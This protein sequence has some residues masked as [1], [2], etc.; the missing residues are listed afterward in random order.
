MS[1]IQEVIN[2]LE[3]AA[4]KLGMSVEEAVSILLGK[5]P[6]HVVVQAHAQTEETNAKVAENNAASAQAAQVAGA[7][8]NVSGAA[9]GAA[10]SAAGGTI[11]DV[12]TNK[13]TPGA[14]A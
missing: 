7:P 11:V 1:R 14:A 4:K 2:S 13:D 10:T 12:T 6:T 8:G 9:T 5:H 3:L